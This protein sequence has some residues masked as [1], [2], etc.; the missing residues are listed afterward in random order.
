MSHQFR[1][2]DGTSAAHARWNG[3]TLRGEVDGEA[4]EFGLT[5]VDD[6]TLLLTRPDGSRT[7]VRYARRGADVWLL[8]D[9]RTWHFHAAEA[10]EDEGVTG[11]VGDPVVRAPMPGK[12]IE[13]LVA[14]GD[15]VERGQPVVRVEAM[16]MEVDLEA[17]VDGTVAELHVAAGDLV[18]PDAALVTLEPA[19]DS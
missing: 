11:G 16:K 19:G 1:H 2:G 17:T 15:T 4:V 8:L 13:L 18:D 12:V 7:P 5:A 10:D 14:Q 9:G 6:T 3:D